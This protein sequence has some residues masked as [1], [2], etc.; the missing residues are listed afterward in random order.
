[1]KK[2]LKTGGHSRGA[3]LVEAAIVIPLWIVM[4]YGIVELFIMLR[5]YTTLN[6]IVREAV[7]MAATGNPAD[8]YS[9]IP[10]PMGVTEFSP[11]NPPPSTRDQCIASWA[12]GIASSTNCGA[13]VINDRVHHLI[14]STSIRI[15][16]GSETAT[17]TITRITSPDQVSVKVTIPYRTLFPYVTKPNISVTANGPYKVVPYAL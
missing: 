4:F 9:P 11:S 6:Q 7:S 16:G 5:T 2:H 15:N 10:I 14:D 3:A 8:P 17:V 1:M 13:I 12:A